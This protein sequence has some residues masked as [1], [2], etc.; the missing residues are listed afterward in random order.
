MMRES[1]SRP[2]AAQLT[3]ELH[4]Q[5]LDRYVREWGEDLV[6][7]TRAAA[8]TQLLP[9]YMDLGGFIGLRTDGELL[10]VDWDEL[11]PE[12]GLAVEHD[13]RLRRMALQAG[14]ER[15]PE[16]SFLHPVRPPDAVPCPQCRGRGR[17]M[18]DGHPTPDSIVRYCGGSGWLLPGE[19]MELASL[20]DGTVEVTEAERAGLEPCEAP[21]SEPPSFLQRLRGWLSR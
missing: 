14:A 4:A 18:S 8:R 5:L 20:L 13:P 21:A 7:S 1:L 10:S 2:D 9:M 16:L 6:E 12:G 19:A 17:P 3:P 11:E 15:Y